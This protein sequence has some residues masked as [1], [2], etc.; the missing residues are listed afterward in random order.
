LY[1]A[2][3]RIERK[4]V[5]IL[6]DAFDDLASDYDAESYRYSISPHRKVA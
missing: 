4:N 2:G 5:D 6:L 3:K 1:P